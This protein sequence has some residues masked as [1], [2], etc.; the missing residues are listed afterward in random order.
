MS[1]NININ[2]GMDVRAHTTAPVK[3]GVAVVERCASD[4]LRNRMLQVMIRQRLVVEGERMEIV[5][6]HELQIQGVRGRPSMMTR[7][8]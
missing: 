3:G 2:M 8:E 5:G 1:P 7:R 4:S 6:S